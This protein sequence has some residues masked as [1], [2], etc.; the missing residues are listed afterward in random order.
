MANGV[1]CVCHFSEM[2]RLLVH[3]VW[4]MECVVESTFWIE[5]LVC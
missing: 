5:L 4:F 2:E 1:G 3:D